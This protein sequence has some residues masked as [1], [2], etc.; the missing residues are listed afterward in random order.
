[1][2]SLKVLGWIFSKRVIYGSRRDLS[3]T[4]LTGMTALIAG[5]Y[6]ASTVMF[7]RAYLRTIC[8]EYAEYGLVGILSIFIHKNFLLG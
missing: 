2:I 1:M 6:G 4:Q 3:S 8:M 5:S 7:L